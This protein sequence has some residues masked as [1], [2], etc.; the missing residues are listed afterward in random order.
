LDAAAF[1]QQ[2]LVY[3]EEDSAAMKQAV[4]GLRLAFPQPQM[5]P[6]AVSGHRCDADG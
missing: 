3:H 1:S 2:L 4:A 5:R 6:G